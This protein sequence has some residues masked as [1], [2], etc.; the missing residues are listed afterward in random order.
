MNCYQSL[1]SSKFIAN[2]P[3]EIYKAKRILI[4]D[5]TMGNVKSRHTFNYNSNKERYYSIGNTLGFF[6][7]LYNLDLIKNRLYYLQYDRFLLIA[8]NSKRLIN[9]AILATHNVNGDVPFYRALHVISKLRMH[10][11]LFDTSFTVPP[12]SPN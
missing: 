8:S 9:S 11:A 2:A 7:E 12:I 4:H 10:T 3:S 6:N 1:V 5:A